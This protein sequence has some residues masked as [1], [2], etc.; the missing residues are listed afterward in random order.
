MIIFMKNGLSFGEIESS[1]YQPMA[2]VG[3]EYIKSP[4]LNWRKKIIQ[5]L[6]FNN[7]KGNYVGLY[8]FLRFAILIRK[9]RS[10]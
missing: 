8:L 3:N 6:W 4:K 9:S 2:F 7:E 5:L 10:E 1:V